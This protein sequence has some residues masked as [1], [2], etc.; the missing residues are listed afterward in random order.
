MKKHAETIAVAIM[1]AGIFALAVYQYNERSACH[2]KGG[3][4]LHGQF[5]CIKVEFL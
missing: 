2:A 4:Y 3:V 5:V 1:L